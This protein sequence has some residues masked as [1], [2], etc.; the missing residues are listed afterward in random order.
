MTR[1]SRTTKPEFET[2][3]YWF[4]FFAL[5]HFRSAFSDFTMCSSMLCSL[6]FNSTSENFESLSVTLI[7]VYHWSHLESLVCFIVLSVIWKMQ[8]LKDLTKM[9]SNRFVL[10]TV[11]TNQIINSPVFGNR[12]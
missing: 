3:F 4:L 2:P 6:L 5:L 12:E 9:V 8:I 7:T 1:F 10:N 11:I